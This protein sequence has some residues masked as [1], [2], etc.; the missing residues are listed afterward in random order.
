[1]RRWFSPPVLYRTPHE[2]KG[3]CNPQPVQPT[4]KQ[5]MY[6]TA[7]K[8][9]VKGGEPTQQTDRTSRPQSAPGPRSRRA[10]QLL[11]CLRVHTQSVYAPAGATSTIRSS[12]QKPPSLRR[13]QHTS[14]TSTPPA[15]RP[16]RHTRILSRGFCCIRWERA[17]QGF[18]AFRAACP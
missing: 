15:P 18:A 10:Q 17:A 11:I 1:M 2:R 14:H 8:C 7:V 9:C 6:W 12:S 5:R 3:M 4:P 16:P 13:P